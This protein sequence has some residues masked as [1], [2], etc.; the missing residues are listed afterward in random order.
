MIRAPLRMSQ[1][2][3]VRMKPVFLILGQSAATAAAISIDV[4]VAVQE[5][6][7][8]RLRDRLLKDGQVLQVSN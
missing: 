5:L 4:A 8:Q 2:G 7:Y 1:H 6:P 3:S